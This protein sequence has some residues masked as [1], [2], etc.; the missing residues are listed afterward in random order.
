M[1]VDEAERSRK[2]RITKEMLNAQVNLLNSYTDGE[3]YVGYE[4]GG[5]HLFLKVG[6]S[7]RRT[8][9]YGNTKSELSKQLSALNMVLSMEER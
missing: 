9:S 1:R 5:C 6:T 7:G 2:M 3:Y 4:N 8:I